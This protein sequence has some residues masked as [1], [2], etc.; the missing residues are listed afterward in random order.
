MSIASEIERLSGVR[1]DIFNSITNKGVT[2]PAGSTFSS[3]P[4]LIDQ[5]EGG[6]GGTVT[7]MIN[8][9]FTA[10]G[11]ASGYRP[12]TAT[13]NEVPLYDIISGTC[14]SGSVNN[15]KFIQ[16]PMSA[17][18]DANNLVNYNLNLNFQN[19]N[20]DSN[21][22][23]LII[24][25]SADIY[26]NRYRTNKST[27]DF[28]QSGSYS[29]PLFYLNFNQADFVSY[30]NGIQSQPWITGAYSGEYVYIGFASYQNYQ[31]MKGDWSYNVQTGADIPYPTYPTTTTGYI[32]NEIS[33]REFFVRNGLLDFTKYEAIIG[34]S[35]YKN[36]VY[37]NSPEG[38]SESFA[39]DEYSITA[40][41][42]N[43]LKNNITAKT[44]Y[45]VAST[46]YTYNYGT[47]Q[48]AYSGF[49]GM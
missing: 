6:G 47:T 11:Y 36:I 16:V 4:S 2:V 8:S 18:R 29:P 23:I 22:D 37:D 13:Q 30:W 28:T 39:M 43:M 1:S 41:S 3:C 42:S 25:N 34:H 44:N 24:P 17:L 20:Y 26:A 21:Q 45:N 38:G 49:E 15:M 27:N 32:T 5:I 46:A 48:T 7:S 31:N 40:F 9:G 19:W 33:G 10:S 35:G 14:V 12:F